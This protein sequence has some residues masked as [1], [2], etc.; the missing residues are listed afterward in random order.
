VRRARQT[1]VVW[2]GAPL[3]SVVLI[4]STFAQSTLAVAAARV[5]RV[6]P[7]TGVASNLAENFSSARPPQRL[8]V[9]VCQA[10]RC[11]RAMKPLARRP[12]SS[13][14]AGSSITASIR[15]AVLTSPLVISHH[16]WSL[17]SVLKV[18]LVPCQLRR[19]FRICVA[20]ASRCSR[21]G[22]SLTRL[23]MLSQSIT[24][25]VGHWLGARVRLPSS[26]P[27]ALP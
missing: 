8:A 27:C 14:Q 21:C 11:W 5:A 22:T 17:C 18:T 1:A 16:Q 12:M 25:L 4:R 3:A 10:P 13:F 9:V 19:D 7:A 2:F 20:S 15:R 24:A 6:T 23:R 26:R